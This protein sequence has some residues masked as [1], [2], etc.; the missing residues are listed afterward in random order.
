MI[1][2]AKEENIYH[3]S[4]YEGESQLKS[5]KSEKEK[6][7]LF[8][9]LGA[10]KYTFVNFKKV[11]FLEGISDYNLLK[12][13]TR[14]HNLRYEYTRGISKLAPEILQN[15]SKIESFYMIRD[16]DFLDIDDITKEERKYNN[17]IYYLKRRQIEN[18]ILDDDALFEAHKKTKNSSFKSKRELLD[19]LFKIATEQLEQTIVDY[20]L[21]PNTRDVNLPE[22]RLKKGEGAED[23]L[24]KALSTK[25]GRLMDSMSK[26]NNEMTRIRTKLE[27]NWNDHAWLVYCDGSDVLKQFSNQYGAGK[28]FEDL[29]DMVSV[30]WDTKGVLPKDLDDIIKRIV[31]S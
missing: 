10:S 6:L 2:E 21:F 24:K 4:K 13:A 5:L 27:E 8:S 22:I 12:D 14:R 26:L 28:S 16:K 3:L 19:G 29:R 23:G 9:K 20:Y 17:R 25:E 30:I 7:E 15:A 1:S 11:V 31:S 18:Y